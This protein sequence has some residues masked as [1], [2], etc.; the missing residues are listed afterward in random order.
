MVRQ[1]YRQIGNAAAVVRQPYSAEIPSA[2]AGFFYMF[3]CEMPAINQVLHDEFMA[4][5]I[6]E[7]GKMTGN[8]KQENN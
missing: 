5:Y 4:D 8:E 3:I 1:P 6:P 7:T 2:M